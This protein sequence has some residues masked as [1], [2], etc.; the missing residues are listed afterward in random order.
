MLSQ[1]CLEI[2]NVF[3]MFSPLIGYAFITYSPISWRACYVW[4][5]SFETAAVVGLYFFYWPPSYETKHKHDG[6]TK[7]Q[8]LK[9]LDY[10]GLFLFTAG[11]VLLLLGL[12]W[13]GRQHPWNSAAVITPIVLSGPLFVALGFYE[14]YRPLRYPILPVKMFK[15]WRE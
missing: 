12:N 13:G 4:M 1:G 6:K 11:C 9:E 5:V 15:K 2:S 14:T 10:V 3:A 7:I 8:L